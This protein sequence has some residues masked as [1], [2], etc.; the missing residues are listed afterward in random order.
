V[1]GEGGELMARLSHRRLRALEEAL[2]HRLAGEIDSGFPKADYEGAAEWVADEVERRA[3]RKIRRMT[4]QTL[5]RHAGNL[6]EYNASGHH[7]TRKRKHG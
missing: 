4:D 1:C 2:L 7:A 5:G 6:A 3:S